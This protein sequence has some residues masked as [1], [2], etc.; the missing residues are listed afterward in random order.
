MSSAKRILVAPLNWGIGHAT[1]CIPLIRELKSQGFEV[2]IGASNQPLAL[3]KKEFPELEC[4]L[5]PGLN[6]AYPRWIPMS[7]YMALKAPHFFKWIK[8]ERK[9]LDSIV[10]NYNIDAVISDNRYGLSSDLV[11][12]VFITHQLFIKAGIFSW[13]L[14]RLTYKYASQFDFCWVPDHEGKQNLSGSLSHGKSELTNLRYIGPLSRFTYPEYHKPNIR[15]DLLVVLSGPEPSRTILENTLLSQFD[16]SGLKILFV[17][18]IVE[19]EVEN[20]EAN[21]NV[22]KLNYLNSQDL[23][24]AILIS[25]LVLCRPGY[26]SI[27]DLAALKSKALFIPTNGQTEQE[28]LAKSLKKKGIAHFVKRQK[29]SLRK[30]Y[31]KALKYPGFDLHFQEDQL[32]DA[33]QEFN[34]FLNKQ[35][36]DNLSQVS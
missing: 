2:V 25:R 6:V 33:V 28:Y 3:L 18:G 17:R 30:D 15:Y 10:K 8:L 9:I 16:N 7:I 36:I 29:L 4:I 27:M 21:K 19:S 12:T 35:P 31:E 1:R 34:N 23:Q 13:V 20:E 24:K 5:L 22:V 26:S 14:K 11:P 32:K